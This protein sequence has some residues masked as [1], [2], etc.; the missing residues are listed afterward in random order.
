MTAG[1]RQHRAMVLISKYDDKRVNLGKQPVQQAIFNLDFAL[2]LLA[3][4][5]VKL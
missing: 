3:E 1:M 4:I 5:K 2:R